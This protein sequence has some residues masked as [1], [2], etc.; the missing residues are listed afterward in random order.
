MDVDFADGYNRPDTNISVFFDRFDNN[1]MPELVYF[2]SA[3]NVLDDMDSP[4]ANDPAIESLLRGSIANGDP[5]VG[6]ILLPEGSYY[7]AISADG[8]VP[9]VMADAIREP[10]NSIRRIAE[11]RIGTDNVTEGFSTANPPVLPQLFD[12][13]ALPPEYTVVNDTELNHGDQDHEFKGAV[14]R[15]EVVARPG[16]FKKK[17]AVVV[18]SDPANR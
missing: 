6:P 12:T 9:E 5:F 13:T 10:I 7:V 8:V 17:L 18:E 3:S 16:P 1:P 15:V 14:Q 4:L 11:D 2:G